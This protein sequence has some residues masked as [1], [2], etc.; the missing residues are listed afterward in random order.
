M[1]DTWV[2][3]LRSAARPRGA[4][5]RD[6][7]IGRWRLRIEGLDVGLAQL[8][9]PRWGGFF[10]SASAEPAVR[11]LRLVDAGAAP[12]IPGPVAGQV[13]RIETAA[14]T[15]GIALRSFHFALGCDAPPAL[16]RCALAEPEGEPIDRAF[17]NAVR[18]L[19]ARLAVEEGGFALHGAGVERRDGRT[20]ILAGPSRAGKTTAVS[21]ARDVKSLGDDFAVVVS[22]TGG[23]GAAAVP[24]DNTERAPLDAPAGLLPLERIYRLFQAPKTRVVVPPKFRALPS[25]LACAAMPATMPD[26]AQRL[27]ANVESYI[28]SGTFAELY[29]PKSPEFWDQL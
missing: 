2:S 18:C 23:W 16:W 7:T 13:Y 3:R 15:D 25:L 27:L 14:K 10:S 6:L 9:A 4:E 22:T 20:W 11:T 19:I 28:D 26:L 12:F 5:C 21:L 8:L 1:D 24:F 17:E 29:F